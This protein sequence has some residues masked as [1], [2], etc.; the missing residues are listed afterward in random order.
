MVHCT[1]NPDCPNR[2]SWGP[3]QDIIKRVISQRHASGISK[4]KHRQTLPC[5]FLC[6]SGKCSNLTLEQVDQPEQPAA[7]SNC[8][9]ERV[10]WDQRKALQQGA[11]LST[12]IRHNSVGCMIQM[13]MV[14]VGKSGVSFLINSSF[15]I[16]K[17]IL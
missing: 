16:D 17:L 13:K 3:V 6:T 4:Q 14:Y 5:L 9:M 11:V 12:I 8:Y 15:M 7:L 1:S 2:Q 10:P